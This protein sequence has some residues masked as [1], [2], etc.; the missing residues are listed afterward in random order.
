MS[1]TGTQRAIERR[2]MRLGLH[3]ALAACVAGLF[4]I[5]TVIAAPL[6]D[7]ITAFEAAATQTEGAVAEILK[8]GLAENRSALAFAAVKPWLTAHPE[9]SE[10]TLFQA[11]QAA[12][13]SSEWSSAASFYRKLLKNPKVNGQIAAQAAPAAYRLLI[14]HL[15]IPRRP[16]S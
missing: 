14:N 1:V 9:L 3:G 12:E 7:R 10:N 5:G 2:P 13:R 4:G 15:A 8:T 11:A 16:I 6:D